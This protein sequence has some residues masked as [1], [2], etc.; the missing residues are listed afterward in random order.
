[1]S[2][3]GPPSSR[4]PSI[5]PT[6]HNSLFTG[7]A[8]AIQGGWVEFRLFLT[9]H[10]RKSWMP[11]NGILT[12]RLV[13]PGHPCR[14]GFRKCAGYGSRC[15]EAQSDAGEKARKHR[16]GHA[17][18]V[19]VGAAVRYQYLRAYRDLL[20]VPSILGIHLRGLRRCGGANDGRDGAA[21]FLSLWKAPDYRTGGCVKGC[22]GRAQFLQSVR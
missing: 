12:R 5:G 1:M 10:C 18:P 20:R 3:P 16:T 6:P 4:L 17:F 21:Q 19:V 8:G 22:K 2:F 15:T 13:R 7:S 14:A 9:T 11:I